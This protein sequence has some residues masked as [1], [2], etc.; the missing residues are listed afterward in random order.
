MYRCR[1]GCGCSAFASFSKQPKRAWVAGRIYGVLVAE[2][3]CPRRTG[4]GG[5]GGCLQRCDQMTDFCADH[6]FYGDQKL[7]CYSICG[8]HLCHIQSC[9]NIENGKNFCENQGRRLTA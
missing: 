4:K 9:A 2:A 3:C 1:G 7:N 8:N 5:V 6:T